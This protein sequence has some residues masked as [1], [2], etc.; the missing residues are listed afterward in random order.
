[1]DQEREIFS[2]ALQ[3]TEKELTIKQE[4][5][6]IDQLSYIA[7]KRENELA[8]QREKEEKDARIKA[9]K[10][11]KAEAKTKKK[12]KGGKLYYLLAESPKDK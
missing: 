10:E 2:K 9:Q 1:M 7:A 11:A 8:K 6:D 3:N 5:L 4:S 12:I